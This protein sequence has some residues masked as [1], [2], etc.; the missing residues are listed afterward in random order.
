MSES[1]CL[2]MFICFRTWEYGLIVSIY[3]YICNIYIYTYIFI[4]HW[5]AE[6]QLMVDTGIGTY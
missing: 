6:V 4:Y 5:V 1:S 2:K 3:I